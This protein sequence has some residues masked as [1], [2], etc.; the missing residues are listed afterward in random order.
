MLLEPIYVQDFMNCSYG[1]RPRGNAHQA[2]QAVRNGIR[3]REG[4]GC[5]ML[6]F[7]KYFDSIPFAELRSILAKR[8]TD[9]LPFHG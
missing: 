5:W 9:R 4:D 2:V 1:F 7:V 3:N 8:V 6:R